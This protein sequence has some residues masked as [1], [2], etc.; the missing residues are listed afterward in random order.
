[1]AC[2]A[3]LFRVASRLLV[4]LGRIGRWGRL[5]LRDLRVPIGDDLGAISA[6]LE[7]HLCGQSKAQNDK[8]T[9]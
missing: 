4:G 5:L 7:R 1:M 2:F 9:R 6:V 3:G 8:Y